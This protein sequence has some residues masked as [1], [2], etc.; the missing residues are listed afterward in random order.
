MELTA[1]DARQLALEIAKVLDRI[2][3]LSGSTALLQIRHGQEQVSLA[4]VITANPMLIPEL[5]EF[6]QNHQDLGNL[7]HHEHVKGG[8]PTQ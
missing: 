6:V 5:I 3:T 1:E 2:T 8:A 4:V 7:A